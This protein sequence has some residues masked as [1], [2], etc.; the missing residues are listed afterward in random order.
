MATQRFPFNGINALSGDYFFP[1]LS[2]ADIANIV[3]GEPLDPTHLLELKR[4]HERALYKALGPIEGVDPNNLEESGWGVIFTHEAAPELREALRPL[5]DLRGSQARARYR[6]FWGPDAYRP[7]ESKMEF[8]ARHG[9]GPGPVD[10]ERVP[11]YLLLV[12]DPEA[13]PYRFQY[14]LDVQ[15]AVG[16][17]SFDSLEEY[18]AYARNI[19]RAEAGGTSRKRR[20]VF[21]GVRNTGDPA[22]QMSADD[23]VAPLAQKAVALA[24]RAGPDWSVQAIIGNDALR[25]RLQNLL[26]GDET[27]QLLFTASHGMGFPYGHQLQR[28]HQ[29][30]L[31]CQDWPGPLQHHGPIR[32]NY[33]LAGEDIHSNAD[34]TGM[35]AFFFACFGGGTPRLDDFAH[36]AMTSPAPI[37]PRAFVAALPQRMLGLASGGALAVVAHVERAWGYSFSWPGA[38]PQ[39][40][41]FEGTLERLLKGVPLGHA[42]EFFNSKYAELATEMSAELEDIKFGAKPDELRLACLWTALN[43]SRSYVVIGDPAVTLH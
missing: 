16:R 29:G 4:R 30:A 19:V 41:V 37:A 23:L 20:A 25:A 27:P 17:L 36:Q 14:L 9:H 1:S 40:A 15:F 24:T 18:A 43:D 28:A 2:T 11:Y 21:F 42:L 26:G 8:L 3:L 12:G 13:I 31:L 10:P 34:L 35:I 38:G 33:Y 6:E 39:R 22:T 5:L 32:R 7:S